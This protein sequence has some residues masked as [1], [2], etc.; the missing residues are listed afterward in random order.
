ML[1]H[2]AASATI[3]RQD[4]TA[5]QLFG[6]VG[7]VRED[8]SLTEFETR[9]V[10]TLVA[11]LALRPG[12][13][14]DRQT[15][16]DTVWP[17]SAPEAA[18][19]SLRQAL[20]SVRKTLGD[21]EG[22]LQGTRS[23]CRFDPSRVSSDADR[24][25]SAIRGAALE[26]EGS[27]SPAL[28][29]AL[30]L[31]LGR[32][33]EGLAGP[34]ADWARELLRKRLDA[35]RQELIEAL[36]AEG[37]LD[38]A[39]EVGLAALASKPWSEALAKPTVQALV[40]LGRSSEAAEALKLHADA[41][42]KRHQVAP[43]PDLRA[44]VVRC[45][46]AASAAATESATSVPSSLA[47]IIGREAELEAIAQLL[48]SARADPRLVTVVGIGGVG[49]TRLVTEAAT[50]L[51]GAYMG[52]VSWC[53][54]SS[55]DDP[56]RIVPESLAAL[57]LRAEAS[58]TGQFRAALGPTPH[59]LVLDNL[60]QFASAAREPVT[61]LLRGLPGLKILATS[62][63]PLEVEGESLL[64]LQTLATDGPQPAEVPAVQLFVDLARRIRPEIV[65]GADEIEAVAA[66]CRQ[67][68]GLP[69]AIRLAASRVDV[70]TPAEILEQARDRFA[71]LATDDE[72]VPERHRSLFASIQWTYDLL[73]S[74][75]L[76]FA[77]L[78]SFPGTFTLE[79]CEA[80]T[81]ERASTELLQLLARRSLV[82]AEP[83]G[84]R[85]RYRL[86]ASVREFAQRVL[87][88]EKVGALRERYLAFYESW[89]ERL[90]EQYGT[91]AMHA[92]L[93]EF[94][95]EYSNVR[96]AFE[97]AL[98]TEPVRALRIAY[99][100]GAYFDARGQYREGL[101]WLTT[102]ELAA[103]DDAPADLLLGTAS[104]IA[105]LYVRLRRPEEATAALSRRAGLLE[106]VD[107]ENR[108]YFLVSL[109]S[110]HLMSGELQD[111]LARFLEASATVEGKGLKRIEGAAKSNVALAHLMLGDLDAAQ[112]AAED[113]LRLAKS[114]GSR[115][116]WGSSLYTMSHIALCRGD[117][118]AAERLCRESIATLEEAEMN[119]ALSGR[120]TFLSELTA[121][122]GDHST[123]LET[124]QRSV[125]RLRE[126]HMER[127]L[128]DCARAA[129]SWCLAVGDFPSA[130]TFLAFYAPY[131]AAGFHGRSKADPRP[132]P[133]DLLDRARAELSPAEFEA[134]RVRG[135]TWTLFEMLDA[136]LNLAMPEPVRRSSRHPA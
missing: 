28:R 87:P 11:V 117:L 36:S 118:D 56:S 99:A 58:A 92:A 35:C 39:C 48:D 86:L 26:P 68:D 89:V 32:P 104:D 16:A 63:M 12:R 113:C 97:W 105:Q 96:Q 65:L 5:I 83:T 52:R 101:D 3:H 103:G 115:A 55:V 25:L 120:F 112:A 75:K 126:L 93:R 74:A 45:S 123:S 66:V 100:I 130:A 81:G 15:L 67:F 134:C 133:S 91:L 23:T 135:E 76:F 9:K 132:S 22:A 90:G 98:E 102:A 20:S 42:W 64:R 71:L 109:G 41:L 69:L 79:A 121:M 131:P 57:G 24:F 88:E 53:D 44:L 122:R 8:G 51:G 30:G 46:P 10:A 62:R 94:G 95:A 110:T 31:Y 6:R 33:L 125:V 14:Y 40:N 54:L 27:R 18:R 61:H 17:E 34:W 70:L 107:P 59:L 7:I 114:I 38:E 127:D 108:G 21:E 60:E 106:E 80:V 128:A 72:N 50:R 43:S 13:E 19:A 85:T 124:L 47:P 116:S 1:T 119:A 37:A 2:P 4:L 136:A 78:G 84:A 111:A 49:K 129:G 73:P 82:V 29:K 77:Q